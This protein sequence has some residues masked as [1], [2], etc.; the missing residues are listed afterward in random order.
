M[1]FP[2]T[3]GGPGW[4]IIFS[5]YSFRTSIAGWILFLLFL[6]IV[7][8]CYCI[9]FICQVTVY[10]YYKVLFYWSLLTFWYLCIKKISR[11]LNGWTISVINWL[12]NEEIFDNYVRHFGPMPPGALCSTVEFSFFLT[13]TWFFCCSTVNIKF[14]CTYCVCIT[15]GIVRI[16]FFLLY[17]TF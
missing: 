17:S 12:E 11:A 7:V 4:L 13:L 14:V 16:S 6:L 15:D 9:L 3:K 10:K 1:L 8:T 5:A 2:F